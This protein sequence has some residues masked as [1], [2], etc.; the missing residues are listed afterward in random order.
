MIIVIVAVNVWD[1]VFHISECP[2]D[3]LPCLK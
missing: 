3:W 2:E 1:A